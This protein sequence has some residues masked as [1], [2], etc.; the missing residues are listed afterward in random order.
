MHD[1]DLF[2][3]LFGLLQLLPYAALA[4]IILW[5]IWKVRR[6]RAS[7]ARGDGLQAAA[8]SL[9]GEVARERSFDGPF[10]R[11]TRNGARGFCF[12]WFLDG[13]R[14]TTVTTLECRLRFPAFLEA[15]SRDARR[16]PSRSRR[17]EEL[18]PVLDFRIVTTDRAWT[19]SM[20]TAGLGD[21]LR[22]L[23]AWTRESLRLQLSADRLVLEVESPLDADQILRLAGFLDRVASLGGSGTDSAGIVL[24]DLRIGRE[25]R[26][27]VCNQ[28]LA[29]A[30]L[31]CAGC[32]APHHADCW[33]YWGRCAI[34][35]CG[36]RQAAQ[37]S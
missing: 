16:F 23:R 31:D 22:N 24:G 18:D 32:R 30:L 25:G 7:I 20:L 3:I 5:G 12:R 35:G 10:I 19:T 1:D 34:F 29:G 17:F 9:G 33:A 6:A 26:C 14:A 21:I 15:V 28:E 27:A 37:I 36:G 11:F 4:A 8:R 2:Q 13:S